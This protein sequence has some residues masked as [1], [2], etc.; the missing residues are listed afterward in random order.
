MIRR[1][2]DAVVV[3]VVHVAGH[4]TN[5]LR[6][7]SLTEIELR[8]FKRRYD[9]TFVNRFIPERDGMRYTLTAAVRIKWPYALAEPILKPLVCARMRRY[10]IEPL[11]RAAE[12][13]TA[14]S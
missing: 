6:R 4:V 5:L 3:D 2:A 11:K 14:V 10:V 13:R 1:E 8:E 7:V 9:A 12:R